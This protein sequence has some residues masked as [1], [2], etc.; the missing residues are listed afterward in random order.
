MRYTIEKWRLY[1]YRSPL[2]IKVTPFNLSIFVNADKLWLSSDIY[3]VKYVVVIFY[4]NYSNKQNILYIFDRSLDIFQF[5][6]YF[7]R[8]KL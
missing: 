3:L 7:F 1:F 4:F 6:F 2:D 8:S 5:L